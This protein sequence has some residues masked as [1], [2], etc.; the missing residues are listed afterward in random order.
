MIVLVRLVV[1]SAVLALASFAQ[2]REIYRYINA[3]GNR[4]LGYQVPPEQVALGY[5][6]L[7][8]SGVLIGV[9]PPQ[10]DED[11]RSSADAERLRESELEAEQSRLRR[12]DESLL[13]RYSTTDDIEAARDR[14]LRDLRIRVNIL[15]GEQRSLKQQ[16]E[17]HQA[18]AADAERRGAT[19]D[20]SRLKMIR[21]LQSDIASTERSIAERQ[22]EIAEVEEDYRRDIERFETLLE[23]VEMRRSL[24]SGE[25]TVRE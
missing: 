9:V 14:A 11:T 24:G 20:E 21:S 1:F 17:N 19:V 2:A 22:R 10:L 23:L 12:W 5:E 6:V 16:V 3:E 7:S 25:T 13:L 18:D 15:K 4:V 8:E